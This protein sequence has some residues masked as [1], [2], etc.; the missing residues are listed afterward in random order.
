[1]TILS[2]QL[3]FCVGQAL[4]TVS[5]ASIL[6][7]I[8]SKTMRLGKV[9]EESMRLTPLKSRESSGFYILCGIFIFIRL[10]WTP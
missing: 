8:H 2:C 10:G 4:M 6:V 9:N 3:K 5:A 1:M 7:A